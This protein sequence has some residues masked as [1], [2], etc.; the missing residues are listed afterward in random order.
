MP[1]IWP[2]IRSVTNVGRTAGGSADQRLQPWVALD[3][4]PPLD[5]P[6]QTPH[7]SD[8]PGDQIAE[9]A[10][11]HDVVLDQEGENGNDRRIGER[12]VDGV[13]GLYVAQEADDKL[14][15]TEIMD[16]GPQE[17]S[18]PCRGAETQ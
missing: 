13:N 5:Q 3:H 18:S 8:A 6:I 16:A 14:G 1:G 7:V 15:I 9:D 4:V 11:E 12:R 10:R 17:T 2:G